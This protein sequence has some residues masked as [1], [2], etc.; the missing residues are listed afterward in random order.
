VSAAEVD[1][2]LAEVPE[3]GRSTLEAVRRSLHFAPD[4]RGPRRSW[5]S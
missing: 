1:A 2:Y 3:P 4:S 5:S